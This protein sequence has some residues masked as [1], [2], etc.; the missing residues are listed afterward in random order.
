MTRVR[1]LVSIVLLL[2]YGAV[3]A[4]QPAV[5]TSVPL[6]APAAQLAEA[7]GLPTADRSRIVVDIIRLIFDS[8]D[9]NDASD[10]RLRTRLHSLMQAGTPGETA[11]LPLD[12]SIWRDTLLVRDVPDQGLFAAILSDRKTALLYHGLAALDDETLAWLGPDRA[13]LADLVQHA[14]TFAAFGRS[15]HVKGGRVQVPGGPAGEAAWTEVIGVSPAHPS[16][17]ARRLFSRADGHLAFFYDTIAH[18]DEGSRLFAMAGGKDRF[19]ALE[20]VF[21]RASI[22]LKTDE[23]P[24]SRQFMDPSLTLTAIDVSADGTPAEPIARGLWEAVF[25][26]DDK[27]EYEFKE[28]T[29]SKNP[30]TGP[31][32]AAWIASRIHKNSSSARRRLDAFLFAQRVFRKFAPADTAPVATAVRGMLSFPALMLALERSG[33]QAPGIYAAAAARAHALNGIGDPGARRIAVMEYQGALAIVERMAQTGGLS[34]DRASSLITLLNAIDFAGSDG[35]DRVASWI[36]DRLVPA[37]ASPP[38]GSS[39]EASVLYGMSGG[40]SSEPPRTVEWEGIQ[41]RVNSA[42]AEFARL[43]NVRRRQGAPTLDQALAPFAG[44]EVRSGPDGTRQRDAGLKLGQ[45]LASIVY[46]A[47]IGEPEGTALAAENVALRHDL[48]LDSGA[49][50]NPLAAWRI[51]V[52]SVGGSSGWML[53]GSLLVLEAPLAHFALRRLDTTVMPPAPKLTSNERHTAALTVALMRPQAMD[54]AA[55]DRIVAALERGRARVAA[56]KSHPSDLEGF[57]RDAGL[58]EWR[59][60]QLAWTLVNDPERVGEQIA[61]L[62]LFWLGT[63]AG[64]PLAAL[65]P[66]GAAGLP[67]E[68]CL[69]LAMP[70]RA[71]WESLSGR[72][73]A[74]ILATRGADVGLLIAEAL[75]RLRLPAALSPGVAAFAMQDVLDATQPAYFDDWSQFGRAATTIPADRIVDYVAAL[76]A[77]G[78]LLP[79]TEN[80]KHP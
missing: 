51:A 64:S 57:A 30:D 54:D 47:Y 6:P 41:Y 16:D 11:P 43:R 21:E 37:V 71:H 56:L 33:V 70:R 10:G 7:L 75:A 12:P 63:P 67:L 31:I 35:T 5:R 28:A 69:C 50:P 59:R 25:K 61:L 48:G 38:A 1:T 49:R 65:D 66:W 8:P 42:D 19:G 4:R 2:S 45:V 72:P 52:P 58:S 32:D 80:G 55:R 74:G 53:R 60:Q 76:T 78:P 34:A 44:V 39:I 13:L 68:G 77:G 17:F 24:F 18:L 9:G 22:E 46:A 15:L 62:D 73:A 14:G 40:R 29:L 23:R 26:A 79:V 20:Q 36:V 27:P 3:G